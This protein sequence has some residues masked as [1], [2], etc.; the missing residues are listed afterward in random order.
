ML[1]R[2]GSGEGWS[3]G[4]AVAV[5]G[6][7]ASDTFWRVSVRSEERKRGGTGRESAVRGGGSPLS[8]FP[9]GPG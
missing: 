3:A 4:E 5:A 6:T 2:P 9:W 1:P 7:W 8:I